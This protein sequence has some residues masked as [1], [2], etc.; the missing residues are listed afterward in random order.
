MPEN[1]NIQQPRTENTR[2]II[3]QVANE[4]EYACWI[5]GQTSSKQNVLHIN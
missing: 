2:H 4:N 1:F 3:L 5:V